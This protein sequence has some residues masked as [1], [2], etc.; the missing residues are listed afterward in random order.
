M[1]RDNVLGISLLAC[2]LLLVSGLLMAQA[3]RLPAMEVMPTPDG[4]TSIL[5]GRLASVDGSTMTSHSCDSGTDRTWINLEPRRSHAEGSMAPIYLQP[6]RTTMPDDPD[7]LAIGEIP[8]VA[9]TFKFM[10]A[11][12]S[13]L[14]NKTRSNPIVKQRLKPTGHSL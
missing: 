2:V 12:P 1:R 3:D 7:R 13:F 10:N 9:E 6:K 8:Q 5:V 11:F 4:C 14:C